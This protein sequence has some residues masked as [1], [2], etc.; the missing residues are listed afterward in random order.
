MAARRFRPSWIGFLATL[1]VAAVCLQAAV[2]Q[3]SRAEEKRTL[4]SDL[5]TRT[6][7]GYRDAADLLTRED[8]HN[9]PLQVR[10]HF[11]N[12]HNILLDNR[13]LDGVAGYHLLTP[14]ETEDG[15]WLLVNRGWLPRGRDRAELPAIPPIEGAVTVPGQSYVYSP[16]TFVLA[17]DDLSNPQWPLRVQKVEMD[18]LSPLLGVELAPFE[19]RAAP[20]APLEAGGH[21]LPRIWHDTAMGPERHQAYAVQWFA[22][23]ATVVIFFIA[24]SFRRRE[25]DEPHISA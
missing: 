14:L 21:A 6:E 24:I 10:G 19:L 18:V 16:R 13:T 23:A 5:I 8:P 9:Y 22:M 25:A 2:W 20:G 4:A 12:A 7:A 3:L 15:H 11:D 1:V 17:E